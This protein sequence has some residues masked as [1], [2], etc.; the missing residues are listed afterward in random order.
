MPRFLRFP[1]T[2]LVQDSVSGSYR[3]LAHL[4]NVKTKYFSVLSVSQ[5]W[6]FFSSAINRLTNIRN[7]F[8]NLD[9]LHFHGGLIDD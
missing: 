4:E 1:D 7:Q 3:N 8:F 2:S 9:M 6:I 5:W